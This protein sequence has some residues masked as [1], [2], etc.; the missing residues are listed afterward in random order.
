LEPS[1]RGGEANEIEVSWFS[2]PQVLKMIDRGEIEDA[3]SIIGLLFLWARS[4]SVLSRRRRE[5]V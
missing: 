1:G 5:Q 4:D 2:L 3:K